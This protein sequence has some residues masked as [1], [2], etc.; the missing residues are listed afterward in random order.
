MQV[1]YEMWLL[2]FT[3]NNMDCLSRAHLVIIFEQ[4]GNISTYNFE[5]FN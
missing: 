1:E 4:K 3:T 5:I 2:I